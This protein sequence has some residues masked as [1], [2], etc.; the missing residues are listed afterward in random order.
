MIV[1]KVELWPAGLEHKRRELCRMFLANTGGTQE[2]G[3]YKAAVMRRGT[4]AAPWPHGHGDNDT[5]KPI[6]T[7]EVYGH[8]RLREHVLLL[9]GKAIGACFGGRHA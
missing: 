1:V 4:T 2:R 5:A 9:V 8:P 3:N 7:A 6:R